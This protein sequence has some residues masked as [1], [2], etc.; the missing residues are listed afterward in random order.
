MEELAKKTYISVLLPRSLQVIL[1][2][3]QKLNHLVDLKQKQA[4]IV[5]A[6]FARKQAENTSKQM[7]Y[8]AKQADN[9]L[10]QM[11][12]AATQAENTSK[13]MEYAA[14]QSGNTATQAERATEQAESTAQ[15]GKTLMVFTVVTIVFVGGLIC[16]IISETYLRSFRCHSWLLSSLSTSNHSISTMTANFQ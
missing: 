2:I 9:T 12:H 10:K 7:E 4:N 3:Q 6:F 8:A 16:Y 1:L 14:E 13:Q 5:E 11:Q 15:Q